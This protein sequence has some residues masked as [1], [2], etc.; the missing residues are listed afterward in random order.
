MKKAVFFLA[1]LAVVAGNAFSLRDGAVPFGNFSRGEFDEGFRLA[2]DLHI[3]Y[4][5]RSI[6]AN[7]VPNSVHQA[8]WR[9]LNR[10]TLRNGDTFAVVYT[11]R[12]SSI[13]FSFI[14]QITEN[15]QSWRGWI[16]RRFL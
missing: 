8:V 12:R 5:F 15:G 13:Q 1:M 14:L 9:E 4:G 3:A 16:W 11:D 2:D 10:Y 6:N 7:M